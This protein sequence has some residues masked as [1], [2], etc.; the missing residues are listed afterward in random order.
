MIGE[1]QI[2]GQVK[3]AYEKSLALNSTDTLLNKLYHFAM[4]SEKDVRNKTYLTDGAV[5][6]AFA[7][8]ELA[9]KIFSTLQNKTVLLIGAGE[10]AELV[11]LHFLKRD[12]KK[13]IVANRTLAKAE[14]LAGK[15]NGQAIEMQHLAEALNN[16]DIVISATSGKNY[17]VG[18]DILKDVVRRR[19]H[20]PLFCIDLAIPRDI[21]PRSKNLDGIYLF[22]LDSLNN[23]VENNISKRKAE[24][25]R[26]EKIIQNHVGAF[27]QWYKDLP[28]TS[29]ITKLSSFFEEIREKEFQRLKK[30]FPEENHDEVEYLTKSLMKKY[31]HIHI[32]TLRNNHQSRQKQHIE[33]LSDIYQE[34]GNSFKNENQD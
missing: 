34:N 6:I 21:D 14:T 32:K 26:A 30:R 18:T 19:D 7:G 10:T 2:T 31:L 1:Q 25:P 29:T 17:V 3:N 9:R 27:V 33:L 12:V 15:F 22:D 8:V 13:I 4:Q 16:S 28:V 11:A 24:I 23:I 5:S 20:K